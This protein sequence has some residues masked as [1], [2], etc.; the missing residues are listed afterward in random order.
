MKQEMGPYISLL[1]MDSSTGCVDT[2]NSEKWSEGLAAVLQL[3]DVCIQSTPAADL[4]ACFLPV[5]WQGTETHTS[6]AGVLKDC[7]NL[8]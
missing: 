5:G 6:S 8:R 4:P 3:A 2:A 7:L 1:E